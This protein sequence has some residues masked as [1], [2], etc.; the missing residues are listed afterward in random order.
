VHRRLL[1]HPFEIR[2]THQRE[3]GR[4]AKRLCQVDFKYGAAMGVEDAEDAGLHGTAGRETIPKIPPKKD[5]EDRVM[6]HIA[7]IDLARRP[8]FLQHHGADA[9]SSQGVRH[10]EACDAATGNDDVRVY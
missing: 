7:A 9:A 6:D 8:A 3:T 2:V 10:G 4:P 1:E 5:R